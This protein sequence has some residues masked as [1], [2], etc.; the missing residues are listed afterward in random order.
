MIEIGDEAAVQVAAVPTLAE[1]LDVSIEVVM[2]SS[3]SRPIA[4]PMFL[5]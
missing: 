2:M 3:V 4:A 1:L 5:D